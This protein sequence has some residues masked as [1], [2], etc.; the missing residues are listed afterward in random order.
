[1]RKTSLAFIAVCVTL[2]WMRAAQAQQFIDNGDGT[3]SDTT[4]RLMW[5]KKTTDGSVHDVNNTYTWSIVIDH[6][7]IG[8]LI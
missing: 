7:V 5:E 8:R 2:L 4:T 1:M 6:L 3:I